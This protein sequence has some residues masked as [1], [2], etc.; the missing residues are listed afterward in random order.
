MA[1]GRR[2]LSKAMKHR[3]RYIEQNAPTCGKCGE[4]M[5]DLRAQLVDEGSRFEEK[6][7]RVCGESV[8]NRGFGNTRSV[9][10][11]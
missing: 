11:G 7:H 9:A 1:S 4:L 6:W 3:A 10:T 8:H 2:Y 5:T